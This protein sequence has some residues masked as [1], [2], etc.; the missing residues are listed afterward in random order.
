MSG[1]EKVIIIRSIPISR[2]SRAE[3]MISDYIANGYEVTKLFWSRG[4]N[5]PADAN[6]H[7]YRGLGRYGGRWTNLGAL[8]RWH[9]FMAWTLWERRKEVTVV[10]S[11]DLDCGLIAVPFAR[12][13][14]KRVVYDAY[15]QLAAG[16]R[17]G[18]VRGFLS[19]LE[20]FVLRKAH[21]VIFPDESRL[22]QYGVQPD[23]KYMILSNIPSADALAGPARKRR[24]QG[25]PIRLCY[26]GTLEA[27]HRGLEYLPELSE[28]EPG[29]ECCV[30]GNGPLESMFEAAA[31]G[32]EN[33]KFYGRVSYTEA[34]RLMRTADVLYGPYLLTTP[35]HRYASPNKMFEHLALGLPL[36][37]NSGGPPGNFVAANGTGFI[38]D[39]SKEGLLR[40]AATLDLRSCQTKGYQAARI[41]QTDFSHLR[42]RQVSAFIVRLNTAASA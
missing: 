32:R 17:V 9:L 39:G 35:A 6:S 22:E 40:L 41:W 4:E 10:H 20:R 19:A 34:V 16:M 30:A 3:R 14:G 28:L 25:E 8:L 18:V 27:V 37:T 33:F 31:A 7:I 36:I 2:D 12:L 23:P 5:V 42:S 24:V 1:G 38:F 29:I 13:L 26:V 11:V 21:V 15:D